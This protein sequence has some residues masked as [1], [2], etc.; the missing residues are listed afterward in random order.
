M[1]GFSVT[2]IRMTLPAPRT[3]SSIVA[4][5]ALRNF[6]VDRA[7]DLIRLGAVESAADDVRPPAVSRMRV[8]IARYAASTSSHARF[9]FVV[10]CATLAR[11]KRDQRSASASVQSRARFGRGFTAGGRLLALDVEPRDRAEL[12][13]PIDHLPGR[14]GR[15]FRD[16]LRRQLSGVELLQFALDDPPLE[17]IDSLVASCGATSQRLRVSTPA[18]TFSC[19]VA[20]AAVAM[21][22]SANS[23]DSVES[24]IRL[25]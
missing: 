9:K 13:E 18:F 7:R 8:R 16:D 15:H 21:F 14:I 19:S 17:L 24:E 20:A 25:L 12:L 23:I 5:S 1:S 4:A 6:Q 3:P 11:S 10:A 22:R 2:S